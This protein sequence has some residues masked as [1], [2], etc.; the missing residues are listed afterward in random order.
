MPDDGDE[1]PRI[2]IRCS[3]CETTSRVPLPDV[4]DAV[5]RHNGRLHDGDD[6]AEVD[7]ELKARLADIVADDLQLLEE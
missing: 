2:P 7:P 5:E 6:V 3:K 4:A 1:P